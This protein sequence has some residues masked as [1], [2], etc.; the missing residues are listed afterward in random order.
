MPRR[1]GPFLFQVLGSVWLTSSPFALSDRALGSSDSKTT[2]ISFD[3]CNAPPAH[4]DATSASCPQ[5]GRPITSYRVDTGLH[6]QAPRLSF[7]ALQHFRIP[8]PFF[9][10]SFRKASEELCQVPRKCRPQGL[11]TLSTVSATKTLGEVYVPNARR[12]RSSELFS[13]RAVDGAF[14]LN[15]SA[16]AFSYKTRLGLALTLQRFAPARKAAPTVL[17]PK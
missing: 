11:A 17:L 8:A 14:R 15:L 13:F 12:L 7:R 9:S 5:T 2:H 3:T 16:P 10:L 6:N 4:V 1:R